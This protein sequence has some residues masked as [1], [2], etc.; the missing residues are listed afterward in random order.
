M[1]YYSNDSNCFLADFITVVQSDEGMLE[2][3]CES[4][5]AVPTV[6]KDS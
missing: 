5:P 2:P 1:T 3:E 4:P 6:K